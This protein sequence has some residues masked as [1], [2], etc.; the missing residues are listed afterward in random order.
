MP[1][2]W[3][4]IDTWILA[5]DLRERAPSLMKTAN[6]RL[7]LGDVREGLGIPKPARAHRWGKGHN[8]GLA[9]GEEPG[10][11]GDMQA[12]GCP[13]IFAGCMAC[14]L[15]HQLATLPMRLL[16]AQGGR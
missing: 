6:G 11:L 9:A 12:T 3:R 2:T 13:W 10:A 16:F 1:A 4:F 8:G 15:A 5:T 7:T 14:R